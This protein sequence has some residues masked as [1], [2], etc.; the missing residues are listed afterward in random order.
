MNQLIKPA[1]SLMNRLPM[2]YKFSLIS[3]LFLLPIVALSWLV[4]SELNRSVDTMTRGV[5]GLEQ[6]EKVDALLQASFEYRDFRAP[7]KIKDDS[8]LLSRS[9]ATAER[10][11]SLLEALAG[12]DARFDTSGNW[13]E[14]VALLRDEWQQL[15]SADSYLGNIDPQFK[16]YQEFV[17][18]V[19]AMLSATIEISGLG[20]DA[21][22]ENL[23]LLGLVREALPDAESMI[24]RARSFG[25]YALVEGQVGYG[26]SDAL[27]E[28]YDALTNRSSLLGSSLSV[29]LDT[30]PG[31]ADNTGNAIKGIESSLM[32]IRDELDVNVIT[33]MR[34]ELPWQDFNRSV[35]NEL[36]HYDALT[37]GIFDV[38][39][40]NLN[41]RLDGEIQQRQ[42]IIVALVTVLLVVVYLYIG[43][44]ISVRTAI[45]R[46]SQAARTVAAGDMT[47]HID[48]D[49]RDELG[50]LTTEFNSMTARIAELIRSVSSTTTDVDRQ[51][52]R[53]NET[54]AANS[55]AVARQ[56]EESG[57]INE[58][59]SQMVEAVNEVTESAHRVSDSAGTAEEDTEKGRKV[60]ADTV[61]TINR[62]ATEISGAVEVIN[63]VNADSDNISQ[64]LVEIK[65]IAEQTNLLALNAA[66]EAAR[67]GEQGRGFAV[68]ADEVRS[69]SQRTHK[70]TE[71]IEGMISRLQNGVK[72]AVAA[73]TNSH[74]VTETT[75]RKS[76]EVT[77]A[78]D[79]IA[80]GI[81]TIVDMSHQIAQAAE[82]QSAVAKNVNT[83]VEQISVLGRKT[84]GNAEETLASSREMSQLTASLQRLV[85]A[86]RV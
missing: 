28:I 43:F 33:P 1:V 78:L 45:N 25:I 3:V 42:F 49:N 12:A 58:A 6:L 55:E 50:E 53:V 68:V 41:A 7:G 23:L 84:A 72:D 77:E 37:A 82:E 74:E 32:D 67:A 70:S 24:G 36:V 57:Q 63:R 21:S 40:A 48:L 31:L 71:E 86:F 69:L 16:Y 13:A 39:S 62:L 9:E 65:A 54:A 10:I 47:A 83:N 38:V 52:T 76:S 4:I 29:A 35:E 85:E 22:R 81:S 73:M 19:R 56:M 27:N 18:K 59:M 14:Q 60:V 75:V 30:S 20:Q 11:D 8:E 51:A 79:R 5:E 46:F 34:L 2:F 64:V 44:F 26:L 61:E 17:Q 66:I 15:R 80:Q